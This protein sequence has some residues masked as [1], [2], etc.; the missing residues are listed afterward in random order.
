MSVAARGNDSTV[1]ADQPNHLASVGKLFTATLIAMLYERGELDFTDRI[2]A[3]LDADLMKGLHVYRGRDYSNDITIRHLL[4]QTSGLYDV[5]YEMLER[6]I[7]DDVHMGF[8]TVGVT[9]AFM[10]FHPGTESHI[11]GTFNNFAYRGKALTFMARQ[12][13]KALVA[14]A[15]LRGSE[16]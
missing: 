12:V 7:S 16:R 13:I 6:M 4:M 14:E 1:H 8:P 2:G 5:F 3:Y 15:A 11:I 10:F 9:G